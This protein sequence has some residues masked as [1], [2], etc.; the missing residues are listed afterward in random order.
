MIWGSFSYNGVGPLYWVREIMNAIIY[1][2]TFFKM[3]CC[4]MT[5]NCHVNGCFSK[6]KEWFRTNKNKMDSMEWP[7]QSADLN[8]IEN[9][10]TDIKKPYIILIRVIQETWNSISVER[11]QKLIDS[12][13]RRCKAVIANHLS[14]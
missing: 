3:L 10:W 14:T 5:K 7:A 8:P 11:C 13:P 2:S 4:H 6:T 12:I 1:I 9:L